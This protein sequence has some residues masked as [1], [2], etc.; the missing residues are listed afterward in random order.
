M[1]FETQSNMPL[2]GD[3]L[4]DFVTILRGMFSKVSVTS[5]NSV[6]VRVR[7]GTNEIDGYS[8]CAALFMNK[9]LCELCGCLISIRSKFS[10]KYLNSCE[11]I[12]WLSRK[13]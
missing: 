11:L 3:I 8:Q 2:A 1:S 9:T 6:H 5:A 12:C 4:D 10:D 7:R 13:E